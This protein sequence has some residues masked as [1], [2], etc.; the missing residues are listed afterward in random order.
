MGLYIHVPFCI[1][2]CEYCAFATWSD[3]F[4]SMDRYLEALAIELSEAG[5]GLVF[6]T[7]F[8]GGGTPSLL[9]LEALSKI[10]AMIS[11]SPGAEVTIEANP[12]SLADEPADYLKLGL[13]RVSVGVQSLSDTEL[14][15]LGR[16]HRS[17]TARAALGRLSNSGL[18]YSV[19]LMY[20]AVGEDFGSIEGSIAQIME[21][22]CPPDHISIYG[23]TVEG[24][25]RLA[26]KKEM[27]PDDDDLAW[28][29][30]VICEI[31]DGFGF[32]NY[33]VSNFARAGHYSKHNW[34]YWMQ[35]RYLGVGPSA[36]SFIGDERSWNIRDSL[37]WIASISNKKSAKAGS[38]HLDVETAKF[39]GLGLLLRT[40]LGIPSQTFEMENVPEDLYG[41]T[42]DR[43]LVLTPK[44]RLL[45][46]QLVGF[47]DT[48]KIT[49]EELNEFQGRRLEDILSFSSSR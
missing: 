48:S 32:V 7:V 26:A 25:T 34:S 10:M 17:S 21:V 46:N 49:I 9:S 23:L 14:K 45:H 13:N 37:R 8:F 20:G 16:D 6:D 3:R 11:L 27:H 29:Y 1:S 28:K 40:V 39:E 44:G 36:H 5:S 15:R 12:E 38:E 43:R 35:G 19:D 22:E 2:R 30:L 18:S 47:I 41:L 33:E 42:E 24:G 4:D 31:L